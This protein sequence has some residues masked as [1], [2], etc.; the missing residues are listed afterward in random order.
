[1]GEVSDIPIETWNW[2]EALAE[3]PRQVFAIG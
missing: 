1:M 3:T 2:Q